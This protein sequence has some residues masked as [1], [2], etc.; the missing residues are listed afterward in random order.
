METQDRPAVEIIGYSERIAHGPEH[1]AAIGALWQRAG[2]GG[3][4]DS[5]EA[6]AVYHRYQRTTDGLVLTI[7]VGRLAEPGEPVPEG[8]ERVQVP[9]QPSVHLPTDGSVP[10]VHRA[11]ASVWSRWPDGG[12]RRFE[13]D[14]ERW[15]MGAGGTPER[16]D[17]YVGVYPG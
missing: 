5:A 14:T 6:W 16:A 13:A 10:E 8:C 4:F 15:F 9:A 17:I 11:W 7:T 2:A 3:L 1:R 12:P